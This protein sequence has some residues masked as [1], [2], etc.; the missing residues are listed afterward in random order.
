MAPIAVHLGGDKQPW[1]SKQSSRTLLELCSH[2]DTNVYDRKLHRAMRK[3]RSTGL[4]NGSIFERGVLAKQ[5]N[6]VLKVLS[7]KLDHI[8]NQMLVRDSGTVPIQ[9]DKPDR[10]EAQLYKLAQERQ[11]WENAFNEVSDIATACISSVV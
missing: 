3:L 1:I 7:L 5:F 8:D 11:Y 10:L 4:A 6:R 9:G 2:I